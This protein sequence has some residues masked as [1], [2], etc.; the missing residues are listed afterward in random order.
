MQTLD[1]H[2]LQQSTLPRSRCRC[3]LTTRG[4]KKICTHDILHREHGIQLLRRVRSP[5]KRTLLSIKRSELKYTCDAITQ[6][7]VIH[8]LQ[9]R[10]NLGRA[11]T[12]GQ[13]S[14]LLMLCL[15]NLHAVYYVSAFALLV[16]K[17]CQ[18][19]TLIFVVIKPRY[20]MQVWRNAYSLRPP[21]QPQQR[22]KWVQPKTISN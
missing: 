16:H 9:I 15:R 2:P 5:S 13:T 1:Y 18:S 11:T 19:K 10:E 12:T 21:V 4:S 6:K 7:N 20:K 8:R 14:H 22:W 3:F 17:A